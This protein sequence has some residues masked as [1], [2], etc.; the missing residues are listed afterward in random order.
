MNLLKTP[1]QKL[2]E[3][4]GATPFAS[5]GMLKTPKQVLFEESGMMP[6]Y[7]HGGS[8][9]PDQMRAMMMAYGHSIPHMS[10]GGSILHALDNLAAYKQPEYFPYSNPT[11]TPTPTTTANYG[12]QGFVDPSNG[13]IQEIMARLFGLYPSNP[14]ISYMNKPGQNI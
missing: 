13:S 4:T 9:T 11:P 5:P 8:I 12:H 10:L 6:H 2:L 14:M 7:A 1:H 3:E